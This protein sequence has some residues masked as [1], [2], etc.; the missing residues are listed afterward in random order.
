MQSSLLLYIGSA[1]TVMWGVAHLVPTKSVV[2]G[3]G[4]I[5]QDNMRILTMEWIAEGLTLMFV[6]LLVFLVAVLGEPGS[7]TSLVV[8]WATAV[9]LLSM[10]G[11]TLLTGAR[12]SILPM[13]VCPFVK[14]SA[15]I[16]IFVGTMV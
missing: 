4:A 10:A 13:R 8:Y 1:I 12:T 11:L 2:T 15:A 6:G 5:S 9:M 16:L 7:S 14:A 3:F